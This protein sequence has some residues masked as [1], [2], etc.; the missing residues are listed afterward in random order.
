[1]KNAIMTY[2]R[3][4]G[5]T[6]RRVSLLFLLC[7][8]QALADHEVLPRLELGVSLLTLQTPDYR[9]SSSISNF[10]TPAPYIVYRGD[11]FK[12]EDGT[13]SLKFESK[14]LRLTVSANISLP[15]DSDNR[16]RSGMEALDA[17]L[18]IGPSLDYR[19]WQ[20]GR[21]ELW[22]EF[23]LRFAFTFESHSRTIGQ[24]FSP[25]IAWLLPSRHKTD[26]ELRIAAGPLFASQRNHAY[27]YDVEAVDVRPDRPAF[28]A[29]GGYSGFRTDLSY[30]QRLKQFWFG[31]FVRYDTLTDSVV[32]DS[33]LIAE[34]SAWI[35]GFGVS[36]IFSESY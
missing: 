5:L 32:A 4:P 11:L 27:F 26:W 8:Q 33:P 20:S 18:E 6:T 12:I 22:L 23:P 21:N 16:E 3:Y 17:S 25:R 31:G 9:G 14:D 36:W 35:A 30:G 29:D 13:P 2:W 7:T 24:V 28:E 34:P 19:F 10:T 1:M 15:V